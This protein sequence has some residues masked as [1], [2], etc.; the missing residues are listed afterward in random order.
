MSLPVALEALRAW[1]ADPA[2]MV[3]DLFHVEPDAWQL[4]LLKAWAD[5]KPRIRIAAQAC[6]GPGKTAVEAWCGWNALL[7]YSDGVNHPNGAAV[8]ITADNLKNNL[9][10]ELAL[11]R[12]RSPVLMAAF[13]M[14]AAK[15]F[16]RDFP[17]TWFLSARSFAKKADAES[18]G[19]TL[20]GL[21]AQSIFYLVDE[22]GDMPPAV[23]RSAEQGLSNCEWG[24]ILQSGNPTSHQGALYQAATVQ[25]HLWNLIRITGDPDN[26]LR[27]P[28]I[29]L[30]WAKEQIQLY[31]RDNP[32]VMAYILGEFPLGSLNALLTPDEV[33][34]SMGR[35]LDREAYA[36]SQKRL[37]IDCARFGDDR[38]VLFPRQGLAAFNPVEMRGKRGHEIAARALLA[39]KR[40][41]WEIALIDATGGWGQSTEDALI[42][43]GES[44]LSIQFHAPAIN[45][46][47][48]NRRAEMHWSLAE[49]V[50]RGGALPNVPALVAE[51]TEL[52]Y[53]FKDGK[54]LMA[55]KEIIKKLIGRS[56]DLADALALT[57]A[58]P[59]LPGQM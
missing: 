57:F 4:Q 12:E 52:T 20:S 22:S 35:H 18:Q 21:H 26:P 43:A 7:C 27:S 51:L 48:F 10:K 45:N 55:P 15:I 59:E 25:S 2:R 47:Y 37:G 39:K 17:D 6:A 23:L 46:T 11:W 58:I 29:G 3:R 34:D 32:W 56:P 19:R 16:Q 13:E 44:P 38:T 41:N 50:K 14:T 30:E 31:G 8:A 5:P 33:R 36:Y 49:W 28:R 1:K 54:L 24:R 40:W 53:T 9:W 42:V